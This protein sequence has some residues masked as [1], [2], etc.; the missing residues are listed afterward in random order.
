[1]NEDYR[2]DDK[3]QALTSD[4]GREGETLAAQVRNYLVD[5]ITGGNLAPG[6]EI[7]EQVLA[8]RFGASRTP[9]REALRELA[10][11]GLVIIQPSARRAGDGN[12]G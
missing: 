5:A 11:A 12:D 8:Q 1:M 9:V 10:S 7:D 4:A 3:V 2:P 6:S